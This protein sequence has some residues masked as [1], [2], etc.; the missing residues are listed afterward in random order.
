[1]QSREFLSSSS[2]DP[3]AVKIKNS[4]N[5]ALWVASRIWQSLDYDQTYVGS[6]FEHSRL[7][8]RE[9]KSWLARADVIAKMAELGVHIGLN[10]VKNLS[11]RT[12]SEMNCPTCKILAMYFME[13]FNAYTF[14]YCPTALPL[15]CTRHSHLADDWLVHTATAVH[16]LASLSKRSA[17][18]RNCHKILRNVLYMYVS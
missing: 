16:H 5:Q 18:A 10:I 9:F 11:E 7:R 1:M 15:I 12:R 2:S 14:L 3:G 13:S 4:V 8:H 17:R 6:F